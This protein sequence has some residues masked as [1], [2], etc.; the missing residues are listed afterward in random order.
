VDGIKR[1]GWRIVIQIDEKCVLVRAALAYLN[2]LNGQ[3][4]GLGCFI[5]DETD[6]RLWGQSCCFINY[7]ESSGT[8]K[9]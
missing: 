1:V 6:K 2:R 4:H 5:Y 3:I 9:A 7:A 8:T